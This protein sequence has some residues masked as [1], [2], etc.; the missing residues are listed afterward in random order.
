MHACVN[1][2]IFCSTD[3]C[4]EFLKETHGNPMSNQCQ[5][6][7]NN[8]PG[9][10]GLSPCHLV[11]WTRRA[12]AIVMVSFLHK[13]WS[14]TASLSSAR[15]IPDVVSISSIHLFIGRPPFLLRSPYASIISFSIPFSLITW[16]QFCSPLSQR[17]LYTLLIYFQS[18]L[19]PLLIYFQSV[20]YTLLIY[21]QF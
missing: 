14:S 18:D 20:L 1:I 21:F 15:F 11:L 17:E 10:I 13:S 4:P 9:V 6:Y 5:Y 7:T 2:S 8:R 19:Y 3:T 12:L 16:P